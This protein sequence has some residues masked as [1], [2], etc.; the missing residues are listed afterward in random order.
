MQHITVD[1]PGGGQVTVNASD[2]AAAIQNVQAETGLT[3]T[4]GSLA[5]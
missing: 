4:V 1:L 5:P 2:P 3:G